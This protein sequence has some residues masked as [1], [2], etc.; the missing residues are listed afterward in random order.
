M[1]APGRGAC[2]WGMPGPGDAWSGV[3][4]P[5]PGGGVWSGGVPGGDPPGT[6]TAAGGTHPTGMHSCIQKRIQGWASFLDFL[7]NFS[8][9]Q[10]LRSLCL[11]VFHAST[12]KLK[13]SK[14]PVFFA[15]R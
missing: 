14:L 5:G 2:S 11:V 7:Q 6:A 8:E 12:L 10:I 4:V 13:L 9:R 3:C 1:P 15:F